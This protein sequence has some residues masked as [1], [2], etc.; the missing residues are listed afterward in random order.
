M[1]TYYACNQVSL[2]SGAEWAIAS[3]NYVNKRVS[4]ESK[5]ELAICVAAC[6]CNLDLRDPTRF[7]DLRDEI[8]ICYIQ[9]F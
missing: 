3:T 5:V 9:N 6:D 4:P 1:S 7:L 8:F 2:E